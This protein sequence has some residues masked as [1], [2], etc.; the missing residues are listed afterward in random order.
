MNRIRSFPQWP[1]HLGMSRL[2][3]E[4]RRGHDNR[5]NA[6]KNTEFIFLK[7]RPIPFLTP[8]CFTVEGRHSYTAQLHSFTMADFIKM[9]LRGN[10]RGCELTTM[11]GICSACTA[12]KK[13]SYI[14]NSCLDIK[15]QSFK[16]P[17]R[18]SYIH[19]CK[20]VIIPPPSLHFLSNHVF[21]IERV[22]GAGRL[23][24]G[25]KE[26][27][28]GTKKGETWEARSRVG[29][30]WALQQGEQRSK[31]NPVEEPPLQSD[32][33]CC[34]TPSSSFSCLHH[35]FFSPPLFLASSPLFIS[36]LRV[37]RLQLQLLLLQ[38][39]YWACWIS[40]LPSLTTALN[41]PYI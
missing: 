6:D 40:S 11:G 17:F 28:E 34:L 24:Q 38:P 20:A 3:R 16:H 23:Q 19:Q 31:T 15:Y 12:E 10:Y 7:T 33:H 41:F 25:K 8:L 22:A 30:E 39:I 37:P 9:A 36:V 5:D 14:R 29:G 18:T 35:C 21:W 27:R 4:R 32:E 2:K 26:K 13:G 1:P